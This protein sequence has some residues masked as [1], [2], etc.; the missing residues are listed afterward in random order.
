MSF[1]ASVL[2]APVV[3]AVAERIARQAA[4]RAGRPRCASPAA[5]PRSPTPKCAGTTTSPSPARPGPSTTKP[6]ACAMCSPAS[7]DT[8]RCNPARRPRGRRD[9]DQRSA[10]DLRRPRRAQRAGAA[11]AQ[12]RC[13]ARHRR[14]HA[15][16]DRAPGRSEPTVRRCVTSGR[17][18]AA[19]RDPGCHARALR[20]QHPQVPRRAPAL[21][22]LVDAGALPAHI[23]AMLREAMA[24]GRN[25]LVSG[26]ARRKASP[27]R[28][29]HR[30][31]PARAP[32]RRWKRRSSSR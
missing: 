26:A 1:A 19:R 21:D 27:P 10:D 2:P 24:D 11:P 22:D 13:R 5:P 4:R 25:V 20:R 6:R 17:V 8:G 3:D 14:A 23:A 31:L 29:A 30:S 16:R 9:L 18:E 32:R 28:G 15:A 12:R 7:R